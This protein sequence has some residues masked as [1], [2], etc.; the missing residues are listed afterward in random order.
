MSTDTADA[1]TV[2]AP[3]LY[4]G[5]SRADYDAIDAIN[6]S[7]LIEGVDSMAH[8]AYARA[9][10]KV[11]TDA[12]R[13]GKVLHYAVYEPERM[14]DFVAVYPAD[15]NL[16]TKAGKE[17]RDNFEKD[18]A[19]KALVWDDEIKD[20]V[21]MRDAIR[22]K[23]WIKEILDAPGQGELSFVWTDKETKLLCKGRI[24]RFC[25]WQGFALVTD[26]K[27]C[28]CAR[29]DAFARNIVNFHYHAKASWYLH[30]LNS[31][32]PFER[33][34]VWIAAE[35]K[36]PY[37]AALYEPEDDDLDAGKAIWQPLLR[38]Y[39]RCLETNVWP[40]YSPGI[41]PIALPAWA[42]KPRSAE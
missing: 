28:E 19:G 33:R 6:I 5:M 29:A 37:E 7:L 11:E 32:Q 16:R 38:Q 26:L 30:G 24:D 4:P 2:I 17:E 1:K 22:R 10:P 3:G 27:S 31:L 21:A 13:I 42:R 8:L 36:P 35:K 25:R 41:E 9:N 14:R 34:F 39:A 20:I 40:G 15:L 12:L 18:N 23:P